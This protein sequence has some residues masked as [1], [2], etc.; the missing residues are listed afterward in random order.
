MKMNRLTRGR[1]WMLPAALFVA[2]SFGP[3]TAGLSARATMDE[4]VSKVG[5]Q[6]RSPIT[7]TSI[8]RV[9]VSE[10]KPTSGAEVKLGP[11]LADRVTAV[12]VQ[13]GSVEVIERAKMDVILAEQSFGVSDLVDANSAQELGRLLG[14]QAFVVGSYTVMDKNIEI[15]A[16]LVDVGTGKMLAAAT[17]KMKKDKDAASLL[18]PMV[19]EAPLQLEA[20]LLVQRKTEKGWEG[21]MVPEGGTL[22]SKDNIKVFFRTNEDC[23]VYILSFG[24]SG[25]ADRLFP[26]AQVNLSNRIQGHVEYYVP[27]GEDW[28]WLDENTGTETM[29]VVAS[30]KPL[31]DIDK[32]LVEMDNA[33]KQQQVADSRR[34][35]KSLEGQIQTRDIGGVRPA[36]GK[37]SFTT[38][39]GKRIE[40]A[41]E[42]VT[43]KLK[44]V[45]KISFQ[46]R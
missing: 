34:M 27:P 25:V 11:Y 19:A 29:F 26:N 13:G 46:H 40:K 17:A 44:C 45:R 18:E 6:L 32:L 24:S 31:S 37:V 36:T 39:D 9:G 21:V 12:L 35:E 2:I 7:G 5:E 20:S 16:R 28:F 4:A 14:I 33:G 8:K 15:S 23:Y 10:F 41:T 1:I 30:Y 3:P 42:V 38:T 22:H 43:G